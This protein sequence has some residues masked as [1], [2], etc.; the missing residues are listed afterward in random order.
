[1]N[2]IKRAAENQERFKVIVFLPLLPGFEGEVDDA[3]STVMKIQLHFEYFTISRGGNSILE[4]LKRVV[5][6]PSEY[7]EFYSLR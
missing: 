5:K 3:S 4:Q 7:I 6:D 2:R 1:M